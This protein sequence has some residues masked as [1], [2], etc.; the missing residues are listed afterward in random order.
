MNSK[1]ENLIVWATRAS[2]A[3]A[4]TLLFLKLYAW[5]ITGSMG[6]LAALVDSLLD[7][8]ASLINMYAV[9]YALEPADEEHRFGHGKAEALAGLGQSMFIASSAVFLIIY[10]IERI[11]NPELIESPEVGT[12][13]MLISMGLTLLLVIYQRYVVKLTGSVAIKADSLHY[14]ADLV[15]N[16][17]I[18]VGLGLYYFGW[19]YS[20]PVIAMLIGIYILKCAAEIAYESIQLLLDRELPKEEQETVLDIA[21]GVPGVIEVH[22]LRTRLSGMTRFIQLHIVM[23]GHL[24]LMDA[25]ELS[26]SVHQQIQLEF[27]QADIIIHQDPH[28][29]REAHT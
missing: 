18:L 10:T 22:D 2:V 6:I 14:S 28:T 11:I 21:S 16:A 20:D 5:L 25:H 3:V 17:G 13:V 4:C 24:T 26:E 1:F 19:L 15:T 29:E 12:W 7:L 8:C 9:R 23:D 27:P